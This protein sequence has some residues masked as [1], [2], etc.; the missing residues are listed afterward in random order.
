MLLVLMMLALFW[1]TPAANAE[2]ADDAG[3]VLGG[4]ANPADANG[5]GFALAWVAN[6]R[7]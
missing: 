7:S 2:D 1:L 3:C 4:V 6:P 5:A